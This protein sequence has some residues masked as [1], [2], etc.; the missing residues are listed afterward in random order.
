MNR[1][2]TF[3]AFNRKLKSIKKVNDETFIGDLYPEDRDKKEVEELVDLWRKWRNANYNESCFPEQI[4]K[5]ELELIKKIHFEIKENYWDPSFRWE[6]SFRIIFIELILC[7]IVLILL[8]PF[9]IPYGI[10]CYFVKTIKNR[11]KDDVNKISKV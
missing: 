9:L 3:F 4:E 11:R 2:R 7:G 10:G 8:S 1:L 5:E 6:K